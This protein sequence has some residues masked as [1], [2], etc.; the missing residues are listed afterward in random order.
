[1]ILPTSDQFMKLTSL[2][3]VYFYDYYFFILLFYYF[4][5]IDL[6][7]INLIFQKNKNLIFAI[8]LFVFYQVTIIFTNNIEFDKYLL[9]DFRPIILITSIFL[10]F[11][12]IKKEYITL[13][14]LLSI[15]F[16]CFSFKLLFFSTVFFTNPLDDPYYQKYLYKYRDGVT[17]IAALFLI[18]FT[19]QKDLFFKNIS[20][21]KL[22]FLIITS[23]LIVII[24]NLRIY[25][26][27]LIIP[28]LFFNITS[29]NNILKKTLIISLYLGAFLSYSYYMPKYQYELYGKQKIVE[30]IKELEDRKLSQARINK[31]KAILNIGYVPTRYQTLFRKIKNQLEK[32]FGPSFYY[33]DKLS[34]QEVALGNGIATTFTI[35]FFNYRK[36]DPK[37]NK[38]DSLYITH[39]IKYGLVGLFIFLLIFYKLF[40]LMITDNKI[41][42]A[43]ISFYLIIGFMNAITYQPGTIVHL[44]FLHLIVLAI[45]NEEKKQ[46]LLQD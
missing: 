39:F 38:I 3:G 14:N 36:L 44:T 37:L 40:T 31:E 15:L 18:I 16:I 8:T 26:P 24:S 17:Y 25:L 41:R 32:R 28:Y 2:S 21:K 45:V 1:M 35:P 6:E 12:L 19:F 4:K 11:D 46:K 27:A 42:Y 13:K 29:S 10:L 34:L 33:L 43:I 7:K 23:F 30:R 9:K 20:R 22:Y 5:N